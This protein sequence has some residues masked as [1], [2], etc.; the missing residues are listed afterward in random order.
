LTEMGHHYD[1]LNEAV[2]PAV[3]NAAPIGVFALLAGHFR[4]THLSRRNPL[5]R[6]PSGAIMTVAAHS[7]DAAM[8]RQEEAPHGHRRD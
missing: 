5:R 4:R 2:I 3:K 7:Q 8:T 1:S 6:P